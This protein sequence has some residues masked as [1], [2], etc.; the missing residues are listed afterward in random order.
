MLK[1]FFRELRARGKEK[2]GCSGSRRRLPGKHALD[3]N[4]SAMY[5]ELVN[6]S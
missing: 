2:S 3:K 6:K 1:E 5:T 4:T